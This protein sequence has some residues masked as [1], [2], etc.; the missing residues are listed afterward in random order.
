M[1]LQRAGPL[2]AGTQP[3]PRAAARRVVVCRAQKSE[4][5]SPVKV[6]ALPL[7]SMVAAALIAGAALPEDALAASQ[8]SGGRI[9]GSS[10]FAS[11]RGA[12][13]SRGIQTHAAPSVHS[14]TVHHSTTVV[15]APP[16]PVFSPFGFSPFGF[17]PFGGFGVSFGMPI[18]LPGSL[19]SG[20]FGLMFIAL[21]FNV[22]FGVI[23]SFAAAQKKDKNDDSWGDL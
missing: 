20:L 10:G 19:F 5:A 16:A 14:T 4:D 8:R 13:P 21:L 9:G 22:V 12:A 17:S 18:F 2:R 7:A 15:M 23:R 1:M 6:M 3:V 11:R